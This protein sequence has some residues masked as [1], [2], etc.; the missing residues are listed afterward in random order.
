MDYYFCK[1][2]DKEN[3]FPLCHSCLLKC[4]KGHQGSALK[5]A[6]SDNLI[7][8]TCAMNNHQILSLEEKFAWN[9]LSTC[10]FYELNK[11]TDNCFCYENKNKKKICNF[12]YYFCKPNSPDEKEFQCEFT[13]IK[14]D[15]VNFKCKISSNFT[16]IMLL[17]KLIY[18]IFH[19]V[20]QT[21]IGENNKVVLC[22]NIS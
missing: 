9:S 7:R 5:K 22:Y 14:I 13:K 2:C 10:F 3:K 21:F 4:H 1:T 19:F 20:I 12:C 18:F 6:S 17:V 16:L 8:C 15:N 11:V